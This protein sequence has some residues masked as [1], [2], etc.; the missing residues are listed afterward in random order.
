MMASRPSSRDTASRE[1]HGPHPAPPAGSA[2]WT[3]RAAGVGVVLARLAR[4][5]QWRYAA[6]ER[7]NVD[8]D[9][10]FAAAAEEV[11]RKDDAE[12]FTFGGA[13]VRTGLEPELQADSGPESRRDIAADGASAAIA[14]LAGGAEKLFDGFFGSGPPK[15]D[16]PP[17][18]D[19]NPF[20]KKAEKAI[21]KAMDDEQKKRDR[22][23]WD[24]R[25]RSRD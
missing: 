8:L 17:A 12:P 25:D 10:E 21:H 6:R 14:G 18:R 24:D 20:A 22:D 2:A 4:L 1:A 11:T 13:P 7:S 5:G 23:Y 15:K 3:P 9:A 16:K 19:P